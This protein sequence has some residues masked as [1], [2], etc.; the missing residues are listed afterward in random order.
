VT[1]G[2]P[3]AAVS[4]LFERDRE[5]AAVGE[6][7][8]FTRA[9]SGRVALVLGPAGIGKTGLLA[10]V[11]GMA[12]EGGFGLCQ[13][14][15]GELE[16]DLGWGVVRQLFGGLVGSVGGAD[17]ELF[18]GAAELALPVLGFGHAA[19]GVDALSPALHGLYW[20]TANLTERA[21]VAV[22]VDDWQWA[23]PASVRFL[24]YL[25]SRLADLPVLLVL[26]VRSDDSAAHEREASLRAAVD[27]TVLEPAPL[28]VE[29]S[30]QL[31]GLALGR[32]PELEFARA[33]HDATGGN[34]FL[35]SEL[36]AQ[37]AADG[38]EPTAVSASQVLTVS[39]R[40]VSH[41]V[42]LRLSRLPGDARRLAGAVAV[43]G[44]S[45]QLT[46]AAALAD[47][48][49]PGARAL[50][51][52]LFAAG[53]LH[54]GSPLDFVHPLVRAAVYGELAP[55][56]L[57]AAHARAARL[58]ADSDGDPDA[59]AAQLMQTRPAADPWVVE[60]LTAAAGSA[61][62]RGAP[63]AAMAWLRRAL[64]EPPSSEALAAVLFQL[65]IIEA[66]LSDPAA[67]DHLRA[68]HE[69]AEDPLQRA[70]TA[71]ALAGP[72]VWNN[73]P[74]EATEAVQD[75]LARLGSRDRELELQLEAFITEFGLH[76]SSIG[77]PGSRYVSRFAGDVTGAT[78]GERIVLTAL[79][80]QDT[81]SGRASVSH[82]T[83]P[84]SRALT[85]G[86]FLGEAGYAQFWQAM[87]L[88]HVADELDLAER[89]EQQALDEGRKRGSI[90]L[91]CI[92][93]TYRAHVYLQRGQVPEAE[94]EIDYANSFGDHAWLQGI[95]VKVH[96]GIEVLIEQGRLAD[97]EV[98]AGRLDAIE[99]PR[100]LLTPLF[101]VCS[102]GRLRVTQGRFEE[103]LADLFDVGRLSRV[104]NPAVFAWRSF[105][106]PALAALGRREE[107]RELLA[108][109][110]ERARCFGVA[111]PIGVNLRATGVL[112]G[113]DKGIGL[114]RESVAA[115]EDCPSVVE[116]A[117]SRVELGSAL[118]RRG[119]RADSL[120]WLRDGLELADR[121]GALALAQ[122]AR[123]ELADAG[124]RP[125]RPAGVGRDALTPA[126]LRVA[127]MAAEGATNKEIAQG[128]FVS[129][130]TV[131]THLTH[132]YAK[133]GITARP[134]LA[135]A[136]AA[137]TAQ[138]LASPEPE[139]S[140]A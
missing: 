53:V 78:P 101:A 56:A 39:P 52:V 12:R 112:E 132:T 118:R 5:L 123:R 48:D 76:D 59:V 102:R 106:A 30:E 47:L 4:G 7:L 95:G 85:D 88:L 94:A 24:Y 3:E 23:D 41:W 17:R 110:L 38:V 114:L 65:G 45:A 115:L 72:L 43:L 98:Q 19:P 54:P 18:G 27:A 136:L 16:R 97:A 96:V 33:C 127:R 22:V 116:R 46:E 87:Y 117:H 1:R 128:L 133:L 21:P 2:V 92:G 58:I 103:A 73:R 15:G 121:A 42:L 75:A 135:L 77:N 84:L 131:E 90:F 60:T 74:S 138:P 71:L 83:G 68:A 79:A 111:R 130:R 50:A 104:L 20:L 36:G 11:S 107:A 137:T 89:L 120:P 66:E 122:R 108:E 140:P 139:S 70:R 63:E 67:L 25:A 105:A 124:A 91:L 126:E 81:F 8:E 51:D 62:E 40:S 44:G 13:G 100:T 6:L 69:L 26:A 61:R 49:V 99:G 10:A 55:L 86:R 57:D 9:G 125:H 29:A 64:A 82:A 32:R 31:L 80:A 14:V 35:L 93:A 113:G 109:E 119:R 37:L 129:L 134:E 34:P 28:S